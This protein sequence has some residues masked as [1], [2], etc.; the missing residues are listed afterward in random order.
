MESARFAVDIA[1][2]DAA[3]VVSEY[4]QRER[5]VRG[6]RYELDRQRHEQ[7]TA[8]DNLLIEIREAAASERQR[9]EELLA[10]ERQH[11]TD[12]ESQ[13]QAQLE[14]MA[15][16]YRLLE[17]SCRAAQTDLRELNRFW[18]VRLRRWLQRRLGG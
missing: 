8:L 2:P 18:P 3:T 12:K 6:S 17:S 1:R 15:A 5:S 4:R 16:G 10:S 7:V 14:E 13:Y 9:Y 11:I